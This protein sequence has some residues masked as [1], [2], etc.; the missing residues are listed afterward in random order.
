VYGA[1]RGPGDGYC[2]VASLLRLLGH[3]GGPLIQLDCQTRHLITTLRTNIVNFI[4]DIIKH[5][6]HLWEYLAEIF[7]PSPELPHTQVG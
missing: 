6:P 2:L 3:P 4:G 7:R 5:Y 1:M